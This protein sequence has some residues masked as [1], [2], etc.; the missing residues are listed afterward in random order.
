MTV[1]PSEFPCPSADVNLERGIAGRRGVAYRYHVVLAVP[2]HRNLAPADPV[3]SRS[4]DLDRPQQQLPR[5]TGAVDAQCDLGA[6]STCGLIPAAEPGRQQLHPVDL[7]GH[8][9]LRS[10][11]L[12][13][14]LPDTLDAGGQLRARRPARGEREPVLVRDVG[15]PDRQLVLVC[16]LQELAARY[17]RTSLVTPVP[18]SVWCV[19]SLI[20]KD[21][22]GRPTDSWRPSSWRTFR[23]AVQAPRQPIRRSAS[24]SGA[25]GCG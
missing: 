23:L 13:H 18:S 6:G 21:S 17:S 14:E 24:T 1:S 11:A 25:A 15:D 22:S 20:G 4:P 2:V 19:G 16:L 3:I 8:A 9:G 10:R 12:G 5:R 7:S